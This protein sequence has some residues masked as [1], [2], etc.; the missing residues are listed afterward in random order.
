MAVVPASLSADA[1]DLEAIEAVALDYLVGYVT[2]D[3]DRHLNAYHPEAIKRR[4]SESDDG[5]VGMVNLS[6]RTMADLAAITEP[7]DDC[8]VE[9]FIDDVSEDI[10]S[11]RLYS[12]HWVD[13]LHVVK[14]RGEWKLLHVTW[15]RRPDG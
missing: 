7:E 5:V 3:P 10:A 8:D 1:S 15:H 14:A 6:P 9:V 12:C 4:Y 13:F 2:G 11:V